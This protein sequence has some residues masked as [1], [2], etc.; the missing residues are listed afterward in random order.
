MKTHTFSIV[1]GTG[2]CNFK[3]PYC[4]SKMT[5]QAAKKH[6]INWRRFDTACDVALQARD[7]LV[8]VI[9]TGTG[10]PNL[11]PDDITSVLYRMR[12][13]F[14]LVTLQTNGSLLT[15]DSVKKWMQKGLTQVCI[16]IAHSSWVLSNQIMGAPKGHT[17]YNVFN[18][19][20]TVEMIHD[21]G[22]AVRL[23]C[24]MT[25]DGVCMPDHA[26]TLIDRC[27]QNGV[28]QLTFR[29][30]DRPN[31]P[32]GAPEVVEW[33]EDQKPHNAARTLY[34]YLSMNGGKLLQTL[35]HGGTVHDYRGQNVCISNCLTDT[36]DPD[37][38]RQIIFFPDGRISYDWKYIGARIL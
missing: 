7:G 4:V 8:N 22:L 25:R 36:A 34:H 19:W 15:E 16:S 10:E 35:P 28:E 23:N 5:C 38:I 18:Y 21:V 24:T 20:R 6:D 29:E 1:V 26:E 33:V 3:C 2:A 32:N 17:Q 14:P 12:G 13:R 31:D 27:L 11:F 30:V 37:D 9:I